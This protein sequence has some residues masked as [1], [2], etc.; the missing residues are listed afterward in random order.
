MNSSTRATPRVQL[1]NPQS[2]QGPVRNLVSYSNNMAQTMP[3]ASM[4]RN[5]KTTT[6]P[7]TFKLRRASETGGQVH[8]FEWSCVAPH[9]PQVVDPLNQMGHV[10]HQIPGLCSDFVERGGQLQ[11]SQRQNQ[12]RGNTR[13]GCVKA[14]DDHTNNLKQAAFAPEHPQDPVLA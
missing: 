14:V 1:P 2:F 7:P 13:N 8:K 11:Q 12:P 3:Q 10:V 4:P 5:R 6:P 9:H